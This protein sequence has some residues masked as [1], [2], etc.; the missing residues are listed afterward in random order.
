MQI[1]ASALFRLNHGWAV[2]VVE[3]GRA[4]TRPVETGQR[5][6]LTVQ[7]LSGLKAGERLI[8]HPDD[9]IKE[10]GRVKMR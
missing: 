7:V 4:K 8:T 6:G 5:A 3:S 10:G 9:K 1:P 2:F